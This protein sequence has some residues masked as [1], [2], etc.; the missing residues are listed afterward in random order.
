MRKQLLFLFLLLTGISMQSYAEFT[1]P[2]TGQPI[3]IVYIGDWSVGVVRWK[4]D[5]DYAELSL[6]G[7]N[8]EDWDEF[9][10]PEDEVTSSIP[11]GDHSFKIYSI[12]EGAFWEC[13]K[14]TR[15][16]IPARVENIGNY[17][18]KNCINLPGIDLPTELKTIGDSAFIGCSKLT[19]IVIPAKVM[20]IGSGAF[21]ACDNLVSLG[22]DNNNPYYSAVDGI[23]Y[24]KGGDTLVA[25]PGGKEVDFIFS[26]RVKAIG[27]GAFLGYK[28]FTSLEIPSYITCI[29]DEA[30]YKCG[31]LTSI[32]FPE[33]MTRIAGRVMG[34]CRKLVEVD[35]PEGVT[36]IGEYAF[37]GCSSLREIVLPESLTEIRLRAFKDVAFQKIVMKNPVPPV[38]YNDVLFSP[39]AYE[40]ATL[41]VPKG[42]LTAYQ[43]ARGWKQFKNIE[44]MDLMDSPG[45][46][47]GGNADVLEIS[48]TNGM[49]TIQ[50]KVARSLAVYTMAGQMIT[51]LSVVP[52]ENQISDLPEGVYIVNGQKVSID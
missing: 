22:V 26:K 10:I 13:K 6:Y 12:G 14:L 47:A 52:G 5:T 1:I 32:K 43:S 28:K 36:E 46:V 51:T 31:E 9:D 48:C 35:I 8:W 20:R 25:Y 41:Y 39:V 27:K 19:N 11:N 2:G 33:G 50:S 18:F 37:E 40:N 3:Y 15:V 38:L 49:L 42:A 23:L 44:E 34:E 16:T 21:G 29:N 7:R 45:I 4:E 24:S 17:A 30:F